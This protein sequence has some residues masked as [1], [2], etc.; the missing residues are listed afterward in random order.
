MQTTLVEPHVL[1]RGRSGT[2]YRER[3]AAGEDVA[4]KVFESHGLTK[5]V[6]YVLLGAPNPYMWC[7]DAAR[8]AE[9][10]R[11]ILAELVPIWTE[12]HV[13]VAEARG[14]R[15][16]D[17]AR[18]WELSCRFAP[19]RHLPLHHPLRPTRS[20]LVDELWNGVMRSLQDRLEE[21]GFTGL[22]WQAG[23][24]NPVALNNFLLESDTGN[25]HRW[26]WI[27]L[28]SG[29]P[30][31]FPANPVELVRFY[32][33]ASFRLRRPMF[34]DVDV[35]RTLSWLTENAAM[36]DRE[37]DG[38]SGELL[39]FAH[40]LGMCQGRWK[41]LS[42]IESGIAHRLA[43]G[44]IDE[45]T[46][47]WFSTRPVRWVLR[48]L[49]RATRSATR[50]LVRLPRALA[51]RLAG[52][53]VRRLA[54]ATVRFASSQRYRAALARRAVARR[55]RAWEKRG[56][57]SPS[58]GRALFAHLEREESSSYLT[59]FGVHLF[60]KPFVYACEWWIGPLLLLT[61]Q[62]EP[63]TQGLILLLA[64][65]AA[66]SVYTGGRLVQS[67]LHGRER[68]WV[69]LFFGFLPG[70]GNLAYPVQIFYSSTEE[71]DKLAQFLLYDGFAFMGR[72]LP[73][74]GGA[75]TLTEHVFNRVPDRIV[76]LRHALT[77]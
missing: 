28:E 76:N 48:E 29:V 75:D 9:L 35:D 16:N 65:P 34:D 44:D 56:Q 10:R 30:A 33:P 66:R 73:V 17:E 6:Q 19:G 14:I 31:L 40:E 46:A 69:A 13:H 52:I 55:I 41:S 24:G 51:A 62:I 50:H 15:W 42:R 77:D 38:L 7:E 58:E 36:L 23:R 21:S 67:I 37:R 3:D 64:G 71:R 4:R 54:R 43:R 32:L 61:G 22:V 8:C 57:L 53:D 74:F 18:A 5:L 39:A 27:D 70:V 47:R 63:T 25:G 11:R 60:I 12:G 72:R 1:G 2:V 20:G 68:P 26:T 59:D 45:T 49:G